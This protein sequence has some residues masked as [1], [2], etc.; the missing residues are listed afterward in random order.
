[1]NIIR[2]HRKRG[3]TL[4]VVIGIFLFVSTS[5]IFLA[6]SINNRIYQNYRYAL[7]MKGYYLTIKSADIVVAALLKD[8][9]YKK[10]SYPKTDKIVHFDESK[11]IGESEI[12]LSKEIH[13]YYEDDK[14]WIVV[15]I[16]TML[17]NNENSTMEFSYIGNVMILI[18]NPIIQLYDI[19]KIKSIT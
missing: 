13:P 10:M 12:V 11:E 9:N 3:F 7:Q 16:K 18:E 19:D 2:V 14:D 6:S 8:D 15:N 1:M 5:L 4:I 17:E